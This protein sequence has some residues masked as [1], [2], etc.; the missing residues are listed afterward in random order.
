M[1]L[2]SATPF[3]AV[4]HASGLCL[5]G[6]RPDDPTITCSFDLFPGEL[7][8]AEID[9]P[10]YERWL[11]DAI[12]GLA[13]PSG[14]D[15]VVLKRRWSEFGNAD[16]ALR[17][18]RRGSIG[19]AFGQGAWIEGLTV[20]ENLILVQRYHTRRSEAS[21]LAEADVLCRLL[22]LPGLPIG[23]IEETTPEDLARAVLVRAFLGDPPLVLIEA[24]ALAAAA[25]PPGPLLNLCRQATDRGAAVLLCVTA[26]SAAR[27]RSLPV[28]RWLRFRGLLLEAAEDRP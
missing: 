3:D 19:H 24:A 27:F 13:S 28:D 12:V 4:V 14:G 2:A 17:R 11:L 5:C 1:T 16:S 26:A 8:V 22:D 15:L 23:E 25:L 9:D 20:V 6:G 18:A 21:I 10:G 7:A